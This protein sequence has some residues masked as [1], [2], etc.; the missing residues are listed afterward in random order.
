[1][2][3][4]LHSIVLLSLLGCASTTPTIETRVPVPVPCVVPVVQKPSYAIDS[5]PTDAD[6]FS[7]VRALIASFEQQA[8][9]AELL[10]AAVASCQ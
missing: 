6:L 9:Y 5:L 2:I 10:E 8:A 7:M 4:V 3:R 1:M